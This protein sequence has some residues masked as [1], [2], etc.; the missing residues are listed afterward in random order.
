MLGAVSAGVEAS[1]GS[2]QRRVRDS[3]SIEEGEEGGSNMLV[4]CQFGS[5]GEAL[6]LP[7]QKE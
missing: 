5:K 2:T 3:N 6:R 1:G 7:L 4:C